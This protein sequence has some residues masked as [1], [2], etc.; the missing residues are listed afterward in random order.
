MKIRPLWAILFFGFVIFFGIFFIP[1][2]G[3]YIRLAI[4]SHEYDLAHR[5]LKPYLAQKHPPVWSLSAG[6][7]VEIR[8]GYPEKAALYLETLLTQTPL[9]S[10]ERLTLARL[11]LS[12]NHPRRALLHYAILAKQQSTNSETFQEAVRLNDLLNRN[13]S[14]LSLYHHM[15]KLTPH[16]TTLWKELIDYDRE[17]GNIIDERK[18][19][20]ALAEAH[21]HRQDYLRALISINYSLGHYQSVATTLHSL[22]T[23]NGDIA[24]ILEESIRSLVHLGRAVQGYLLYQKVKNNVPSTDSLEGVA[25]IFYQHGY[26]TLAL[27]VFEDLSSRIPSSRK[28]RDN[29]IWLSDQLGWFD[30][31]RA[32]LV[33]SGLDQIDTPE[34]VRSRILDLDI[35]YHRLDLAQSDLIRWMGET[36]NALSVLRLYSD[37]AQN[38]NNLPLAINLLRQANTLYPGRRDLQKSLIKLYLWNNQPDNA[39]SLALANALSS[40]GVRQDL[41]RAERQFE[42]ANRPESAKGVLF[43]V[44]SRDTAHDY[45]SDLNHLFTLFNQT[46]QKT[47]LAHLAQVSDRF[48]DRFGT[49]DLMI[50]QTFVWEKRVHAAKRLL[51]SLIRTHPNNRALLFSASQWFDDLNHPEIALQYDREAYRKNPGDPA[52]IL[53]L[54]RHLGELGKYRDLP[55][56]YR[57]LLAIDPENRQAL[58]FI[59]NDL[60]NHGRYSRAIVYFRKL[61][62]LDQAGHREIFLMASSYDRI[63]NRKMA[64]KYY[65]LAMNLLDNHPGNTR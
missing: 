20:E 56:L 15:L 39:G 8:R 10:R 4:Q 24:P 51:D 17:S 40:G 30:Q 41:L 35:R 52:A 16:D 7:E 11:Y 25:W 43:R 57:Q 54:S 21:P 47:G 44:V 61:L 38:R 14:V 37:Y 19:L 26:K 55:I 49:R 59:G 1:T 50:V 9:N 27:S 12:M 34:N 18:A 53:R 36:Q 3:E 60:Y 29:E 28:Y 31:A 46:T 22:A 5:L 42:D 33:K 13:R 48:P 32:F 45:L 63:G 2:Q 58:V 23:L 62:R 6:A 65:H 64:W